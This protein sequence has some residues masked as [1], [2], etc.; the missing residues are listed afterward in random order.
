MEEYKTEKE[1]LK[2]ISLKE[3]I[4]IA[5]EEILSRYSKH[6]LTTGEHM[7]AGELMAGIEDNNGW[8]KINSRADL[9]ESEGMYLFFTVDN[10][11]LEL[12]HSHDISIG[13]VTHWRTIRT[14]PKPI[15]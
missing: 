3:S 13:G 9:P 14:I 10:R 11:S 7:K 2:S 4:T 12:Y 15:Y 5:V 6:L 1:F 8:T